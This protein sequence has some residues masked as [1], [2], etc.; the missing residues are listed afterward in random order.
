VKNAFG[1]GEFASRRLPRFGEFTPKQRIGIRV[2]KS[3]KWTG[4][5][6]SNGR[7]LVDAISIQRETM[8]ETNVESFAGAQDSKTPSRISA[9]DGQLAGRFRLA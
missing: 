7:E 8:L 9:R 6:T 2:R 1:L 5:S 3:R 4:P